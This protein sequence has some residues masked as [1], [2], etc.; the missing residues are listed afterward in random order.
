MEARRDRIL[1]H[2]DNPS[3][4]VSGTTGGASI[5]SL[6]FSQQAEVGRLG[7]GTAGHVRFLVGYRFRLDRSIF[8][9]GH[10]TVTRDGTLVEASDVTT[11]E[12]TSGQE[13]AILGGTAATWPLPGLWHLSASG[14]IAPVVLARLLVQLPDKYPGQDL[15]FIGKV[16]AGSARI[17]LTRKLHEWETAVL[18]DAGTTW[19]Y[20]RTARLEH[21]TLGAQLSIGR[22]W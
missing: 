15:V 17:R 3:S 20:T 10:K 9:T 7:A 13:H 19:S 4:I 16:A 21:R 8:H 5:R 18:V 12:M 22:T 6:R 2:F 14:E 1:Y 11:R